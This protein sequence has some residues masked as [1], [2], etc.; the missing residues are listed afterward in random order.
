MT[1]ADQI[2]WTIKAYRCVNEGTM[3][4][5][6]T[7]GRLPLVAGATSIN[8]GGLAFAID[9][10]DHITSG[11]TTGTLNIYAY[12]RD[13]ITLDGVVYKLVSG[14]VNLDTDT[15]TIVLDKALAADIKV[16]ANVVANYE[17]KDANNNKILT[18]PSVD[19]QLDYAAVTAYG[20]RAQYTASIDAITQMQNEL[21]VDMRAAFVAV[22]IAKLMFEQSCR[23]LSDAKAR[24]V[25]SGLI[26]ELDLTRGSDMTAAFNNTSSIAAEIVPAVEETKRRICEDTAHMPSGFDIFVTGSLSTLMRSLADDT[27]FVPS[28]LTLGTPNNMVRLG[29]RGSDNYYYIPHTA[30]VLDEGEVTINVGGTPTAVQFAEA[31]VCARNEMAAK[32]MFVGHIAVPVVTEDVRAQMFEQGVTFYTR[33]AAD[34]N[35]HKRFGR[36]SF[37]LRVLNL[38]KSLTTEVA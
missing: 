36:Q 31:L 20:I 5:D 35:K 11:K 17:A 30:G 12:D 37:V 25:G 16:I 38:P 19:A 29:S 7:S 1:S 4:P 26:R 9:Q 33:Q 34:L 8:I 18:A 27:N 13:G 22:V 23:L 14:T 21:G 2:T 32:S 28:G 3:T 10:Q 24:A 6:T 15:V